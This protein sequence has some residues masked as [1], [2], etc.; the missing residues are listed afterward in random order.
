MNWEKTL[1]EMIE[2]EKSA[3][4]KT[5]RRI[6]PTLTP[7]DLL[8]PNDY[9]ELENNAHFRYEEGF[10]AGLQAALTALRALETIKF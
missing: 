4:L 3:L 5:G 7:E 10:L 8:Q 9:Q 6:V 1:T 2:Q